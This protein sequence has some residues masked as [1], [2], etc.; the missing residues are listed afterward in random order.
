MEDIGGGND[1][2]FYKITGFSDRYSMDELSIL[3][4][5]ALILTKKIEIFM[6]RSKNSYFYPPKVGYGSKNGGAIYQIAT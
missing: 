2:L 5:F 3:Q 6:G 4:L 1:V